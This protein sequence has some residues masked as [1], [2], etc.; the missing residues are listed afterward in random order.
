MF[1]FLLVQGLIN[2]PSEIVYHLLE[3][4]AD[5]VYRS[6]RLNSL[7][8]AHDD[9]P[10]VSFHLAVYNLIVNLLVFLRLSYFLLELLLTVFLLVILNGN[11][12]LKLLGAD[13]R[14]FR[15]L[16][17]VLFIIFGLTHIRIFLDV[18]VFI[19]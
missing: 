19:L 4:H 1:L 12:D 5:E 14:K 10:I 17:I 8:F 6:C 2:K 9:R 15:V 7:H 3:V 13:D 11:H 18:F 16:L